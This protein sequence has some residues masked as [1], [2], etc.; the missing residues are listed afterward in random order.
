[1]MIRSRIPTG[2]KA[3]E[4]KERRQRKKTPK[5]KPGPV[6]GIRIYQNQTAVPLETNQTAF[7]QDNIE[8]VSL[9]ED[10]PLFKGGTSRI[11]RGKM[12]VKGKHSSQTIVIKQPEDFFIKGT[13]DY[14]WMLRQTSSANRKVLPLIAYTPERVSEVINRLNQSKVP[15]PK[16]GFLERNGRLFI[17]MEPF[18]GK[19][20]NRSTSKFLPNE[21][22]LKKLDLH[23][24]ADVQAFKIALKMTAQLAHAG[25]YIHPMFN[26]NKKP[27]SD[28]FNLIQRASGIPKLIVQDIDSLVVQNN[29]RKN[30]Q[31]ST[32]HLKEIV[33]GD[34]PFRLRI[35]PIGQNRWKIATQ[36][37]KEVGKEAGLQ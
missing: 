10:T 33:A 19:S 21:D 17:L 11:Y 23:R 5:F 29:P 7:T 12:K 36:A 34:I 16:M 14:E 24:P 28:V 35:N 27:R 6:K 32:N 9:G 2:Q 37:I 25:L 13:S 18:I 4:Y 31:I 15:H 20:G 30:W 1:M 22:P 26:I 8:W 3:R